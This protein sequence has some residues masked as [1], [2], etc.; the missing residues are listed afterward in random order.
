MRT[1]PVLVF[2]AIVTIAL[3]G[4]FG[5][6]DGPSYTPRTHEFDLYV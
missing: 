6:G 4:C 1:F 2:G 3:G 5:V